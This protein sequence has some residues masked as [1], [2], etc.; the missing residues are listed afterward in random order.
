MEGHTD[1]RKLVE[2]KKDAF[3]PI[4]AFMPDGMVLTE[5]GLG[6]SMPGLPLPPVTLGGT[7]AC[8]FALWNPTTPGAYGITAPLM[9][10]QALTAMGDSRRVVVSP[11]GALVAADDGAGDLRVWGVDATAAPVE[12]TC[13]GTCQK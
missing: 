13:M 3:S 5:P 6:L 10:C 4:G 11:D 8:G 9:G 12:A 2:E 7:F 1:I